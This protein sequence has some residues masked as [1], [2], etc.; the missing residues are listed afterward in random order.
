MTTGIAIIGVAAMLAAGQ[1]SWPT[2]ESI[3]TLAEFRAAS[4]S[5]FVRES[6][7]FPQ[8]AA[9]RSFDQEI[10]EI[11][12]ALSERQEPLGVEFEAVWDA[13]SGQLYED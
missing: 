13:N 3:Y 8:I 1:M 7:T 9:K 6:L 10:A 2:D 4:Y 11:Y 5:P 12:A